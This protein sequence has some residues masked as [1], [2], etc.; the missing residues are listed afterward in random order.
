LITTSPTGEELFVPS[1]FG[2]VDDQA[3]VNR[4]AGLLENEL[5][6]PIQFSQAAPNLLDAA[7]TNDPVFMFMGEKIV[8]G[9]LSVSWNQGPDG[10]CVGFGTTRGAWDAFLWEIACGVLSSKDPGPFCVEPT[11][12][13]S[14]VE[15]GGGRIRG[16]GSV[17][18]W[19]MKWATQWGFIP[20][21]KYVTT[22]GQTFDL[23]QYD[24]ALCRRWATPGV[25]VPDALE[26]VVKQ[27]P[28]TAVAMVTTAV[29]LWAALG[30]GKVVP[31]CSDVGFDSPLDADGFCRVNG[32]WPHCMGIIAR[33][34]H[35]KYGRCVVV[36]NSW[37]DYLKAG[38][39]KVSFVDKDGTTKQ[40]DLPPGSFCTTLN[41]AAG[42]VAQRDSWAL[43]GVAGWEPVLI[44][45]YV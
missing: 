19:A 11:Y 5:Q 27:H 6:A 31:V 18:V 30:S 16:D 44:D 43:A 38:F 4:V 8:R 20:R 21:G 3:E 40:F 28:A 9:E 10:F 25:G 41:V 34:F 2:W 12:A 26:P 14:R 17:G 29:E 13:G 22:D 42:M 23:T 36:R 39:R 45:N 33:F 15:V 37:G 24:R 35:P 1:A 32:T 7:D